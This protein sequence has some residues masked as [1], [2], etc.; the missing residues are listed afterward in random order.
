MSSTKEREERAFEALIV[1]QLR[2]ECDPDKVKPE[3]AATALREGEGSVEGL[4][5]PI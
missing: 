4:S 1:S 5:V 3:D 2:K